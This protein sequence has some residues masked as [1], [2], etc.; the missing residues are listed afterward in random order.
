M[1]NSQLLKGILEGCVL[2]VISQQAVYGYELVAKLR[3]LGFAELSAGTVYP[4]LQKLERQGHLKSQLQASS[5]GPKRKY[6]YLTPLGQEQLA[7][8]KQDWQHLTVTVSNIIQKT[9]GMSDDNND[10]T[11]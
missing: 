4:L 9:G 3:E 2:A 10:R 7:D 11:K 6:Y 1:N 5:E 8:F